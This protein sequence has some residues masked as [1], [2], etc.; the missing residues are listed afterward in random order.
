[1]LTINYNFV[2]LVWFLHANMEISWIWYCVTPDWGCDWNLP[3]R[4]EKPKKCWC[5]TNIFEDKTNSE[6]V[7]IYTK[8][9]ILECLHEIMVIFSYSKRKKSSSWSF[10]ITLRFGPLP[11]LTNTVH[12]KIKQFMHHW[13][14]LRKKMIFS[15]S[16]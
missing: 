10:Y 11:T 12:P 16:F 6:I 14:K 2:T 9:D 8:Q 13:Q 5:Y 4:N 3:S 1:M 15:F 7:Q